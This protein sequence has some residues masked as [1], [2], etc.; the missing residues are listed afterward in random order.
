MSSLFDL[1]RELGAFRSAA[2]WGR[3]GLK[4]GRHWRAS[5]VRARIEA[6]YDAET[7]EAVAAA[8]TS[9]R[10]PEPILERARQRKAEEAHR[11]KLLSHPPP[12][13]GSAAWAAPTDLA[14]FLKGRDGFDTPSSILLGTYLEDGGQAPSG[15]VHW[16][17]DGHLLT[18][19]PTRSGKSVTTIIPNLLRY[20]G[21]AVV[22]DPKGE[23]YEA[24]SAWRAAN[25]G[26]VYRIAPFD[27]GSD[28]R[29]ANFPR[30]GF[31]PLFRLRSQHQARGL[32]QLMFPRDPNGQEF[33]N[34]DA[35]SFL[36]GLIQYILNAAPPDRRNL[37]TVREA[38]SAPIDRFKSLATH[39]ASSPLVAVR[40]A[41][42]NVLGKS[43]DRGLPNLRD[44]LH[45]KLALWSDPALLAATDR[46]DVDFTKLKD[47]PATVYITVPLNLH[48]AYAPFI[49]VLLKAALD[50]MLD[51]PAQPKIPV[52][53]VLDEF[54]SLGPFA[55]FRNAIRTHAAAGVRLWFFL[56]DMGT[57]EEHY[58]GKA[59][60]AFLNTSV[61]QFF[62]IDDP[63]TAELVGRYLGNQTVAY[64]STQ[65]GANV[66]AQMGNWTSDGSAGVAFSSGES[67]QFLGRPLMTPDEVM[68]LLSDWHADGTRT[69]IIHIRGPRAFKARL[70]PYD[71][72][73]T[74]RSRLGAYRVGGKTH[75]TGANAPS[76]A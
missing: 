27:D 6:E 43:G 15:F 68:A 12:L 57:L 13:H 71:F 73:E 16:D 28:A 65:S 50:A 61:K 66:S 62:G 70:V 35:V 38:T 39:M 74:C 36:T 20:R 18:L 51:N 26:P 49:K 30:H 32:A 31:N 7:A 34:D 55:D 63:F 59:W 41:A 56:Q 69:G 22:L 37:G 10:N 76:K 58:P 24:T 67:I 2:K 4:A 9:G 8:I 19:A 29:T 45:S 72:S 33:F 21:S 14:R 47:S 42:N 11:D 44:T 60:H 1:S 52:L 46:D 64:R 17:G 3:W 40:E 25:V 48:E 54:L 5:R 23:L 53:F 75:A